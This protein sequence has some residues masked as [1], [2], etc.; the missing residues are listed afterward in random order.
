MA[1]PYHMADVNHNDDT[2]AHTHAP[3]AD[4]Y[5]SHATVY[6][7]SWMVHLQSP[8]WSNALSLCVCCSQM[9][10]LMMLLKG[11]KAVQKMLTL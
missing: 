1:L 11:D 5:H 9:M 6:Q 10:N 8:D 2:D 4:G 7:A 3:F